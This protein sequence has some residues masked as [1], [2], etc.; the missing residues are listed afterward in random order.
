LPLVAIIFFLKWISGKWIIFWC[1]V[2]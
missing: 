1:L 2:V